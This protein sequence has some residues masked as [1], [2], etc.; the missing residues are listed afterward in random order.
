MRDF[1]EIKQMLT[2]LA[3]N[4]KRIRAVLLQ[5]SRA[6]KNIT[7]DLLQDFDIVFIVDQMESFISD[8]R[9]IS[10]FGEKLISQLP[11]EMEIGH[12]ESGKSVSF[13]YL[14]LFKD[15][16]RIDLS[17]F[18]REKMNSHFSPDS[19]TTVWLDKDAMFSN[20]EIPSDKDY[21]IRRP[22]EK[23][24]LE[25]CNEFW[26][27]S[28]YVGKGLLRREI[29]Y[30]KAMMEGPVRKMFM[31]MVEWYIGT[32]TKFS[33]SFGKAGKFMEKYLSTEDYKQI[34]ATYPDFQIENIWKSLFT[35]TNLFSN[36]AKQVADNLQFRQNIEEQE[37]V[38]EHLRRQFAKE[39]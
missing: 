36:Y 24:F 38:K 30:A 17:L 14:M 11:D 19:L 35:M 12:D 37:N 22:A 25:T 18:P 4:D 9:W 5:G 16:V 7:H 10:V 27:V 33:V 26:W 6:N 3:Q 2:D 32:E 39:K 29:T 8:H 20:I 34:L 31:R 15:G 23:E 28:L 21:L 1:A 13:H